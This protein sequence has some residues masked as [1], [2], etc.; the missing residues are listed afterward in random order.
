MPDSSP[1]PLQELLSRL[2]E[3][4][5][6]AA[7][8]PFGDPVLLIALAI[9]RRLDDGVLDLDGLAD[10]VQRL[11]DAAAGD[12][13]K[14][15]AAYVGLGDQGG[16]VPDMAALAARLVRP[17]PDDSPVPFARYRALLETPRFAAVF[18]AHPTFS[19]PPETGAALAAAASGAAFPAG[20]SHRPS[21]PTLAEEFRQAAAA[22]ARGRDAIDGLTEALLGAAQ[23]VWPDRWSSLVPRPVL[24]ASWVGYDTDGRTD[25]GWW[26]TLR[27]RLTMKRLQLERLAGQFAAL[28]DCAAPLA[29]RVG[30]A[31]AAVETQIAAVPE[32]PEP[33]AVQA[34]AT[35]LIG[36][37][38]A[39][40]VG[41]EPLLALFPAALAAA[42]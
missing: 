36:G 9:S 10:M 16:G 3:T 35:A 25:I 38:E 22:I 41:T 12:R 31:L 1:D 11:A 13:A 19:L 17:D 32:K 27:L 42:P 2:R 15:I 40:M 18:T 26:D 21:A 30:E 8:D 39:A 34:M 33:L 5:A 4:R 37:R 29:A 14:R 24:L 6:A 23:A 28:G 20:L 7:H